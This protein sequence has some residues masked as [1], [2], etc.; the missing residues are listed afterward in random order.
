TIRRICRRTRQVLEQTLQ[1]SFPN[2]LAKVL[3]SFAV[4]AVG[5]VSCREAGNHFGNV[6]GRNRDNRKTVR[7]R[8]VIPLASEDHLEVRHGV[9]AHFAADTIEPQVGHV[10]LTATVEAPADLDVEIL[11]GLVHL[12]VL[13]GKLFP[14]LR[15]EAARR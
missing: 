6:L 14:K 12:K 4:A 15:G 2:S 7:S 9:A 13:L 3:E 10:M 5:Y 11:D 8:V 1:F